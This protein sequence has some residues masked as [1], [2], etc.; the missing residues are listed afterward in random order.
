MLLLDMHLNIGWNPFSQYALAF[1][2]LSWVWVLQLQ[3][4]R[5]QHIPGPFLARWT[6]LWLAYYAY[7]GRRYAAVHDAHQRY[8]ALVRIAPNH[9]SIAS[10]DALSVVYGQGTNAPAKS[11]FYNAFV[12]D[13]KPSLFSTRDRQDHSKKRR[14]VSH[15]FSSSALREFVPMIQLSVNRFT[16]RMDEL[17]NKEEFFDALPWFNYLAFDILSDLVFGERIGMVDKGSDVVTINT[18]SSIA[19]NKNAI[20]LVDER[21]HF[22]AVIGIHPSLQWA[23]RLMSFLPGQ[24]ASLGLEELGRSQVLKRLSS[25]TNRNDMLGKLIEAHGF[26]GRGPSVDEIGELTAESV[27]LLIAGSDTT[28]N[29]VAVILHFIFTHP[30]VYEKLL[31]LLDQAAAGQKELSYEQAKDIPYLQ[32]T[33]NEGL[34]LHSVNSIG[35]HRSAPSSGLVYNGHFFPEGTELSVPAWTISHSH[36]LWGDPEVFR[37]ER[38]Q[39]N[40]EL[41]QYLL[42]FG[43][44]P[45]ACI[46]KNLAYI[47]M[48]LIVATML[49]RYKI[50]VRS[51]ELQTTEGFMHKPLHFWIKLRSI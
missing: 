20:A 37:P 31:G 48:I 34:R 14:A 41:R 24:Q 16:K 49:L 39:E 11:P 8:G 17:C 45:R 13:G 43:K 3:R 18:S 5:Q 22:S 27:T 38:W 33:I 1:V 23:A 47:E 6:H 42:A 26:D 35:L 46:G 36:E 9:V 12:C 19:V 28:S 21:E 50:E 44:G 2:A 15:A 32:A 29:S 40:T 30:R 7:R 4:R 10:P 25:G 51:Q